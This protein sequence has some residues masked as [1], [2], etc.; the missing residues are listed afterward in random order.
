MLGR[1]RNVTLLLGIL[2]LAAL[3]PVARAQQPEPV[4]A[5]PRFDIERFVIEGNTLL[6]QEGIDR[7]VAPFSG[8]EK[9]FA[10]IQRALE[11]LEEAYRSAGWGLVQVVLPEQDITKGT[12]RFR[13]V[14]ARLS[15]VVVEGNQNFSAANI[16]RS[17]PALRE[18][19]TPNSRETAKNLQVAAENPGKQTTALL[20][21]GENEGEVI[22]VVQVVEEK[23]WK[24][25]ATLDN[26]GSAQTGDYRL[27]LGFLH[28][29]L[30]DRDHM[31]TAQ[32]IT[33][34][35]K[36]DEVKIFGAGYRIPLYS[37]GASIDVVAGYSD[38]NSGTVQNLFTVSGSGTIGA[39]RYNQHLPRLAD[40]EH[41]IVYGL[42]YRAYQNRVLTQGQS[43]VPDI[44][45]HPISAYYAGTY[46]A[47]GN[48][49]S[50]YLYAAQNVHP[51]GND[52][53]DDVFKAT[54]ADAKAS[55]RLYRYQAV[56]SRV[57]LKEWQFRATLNGQHSD[58]A[59]IPG[60]QF[61]VGG[62]ETVRGFQ[63]REVA[64]DKGFR[65]SLEV[66]SP[67]FGEK[68]GGKDFHTRALVFFDTASVY[69]NKA[70][71][72]EATE[73]SISSAGFGLRFALGKTASA[74][75]DYARVLD[76][77][78]AQ[79]KGDQRLHFSLSVVY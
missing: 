27:G 12:V 14:E 37:Q 41:K 2:A 46:R 58:E 18:G 70:Q 44:T 59:L 24:I 71:P 28:A 9:D 35:G 79:G 73:Q 4:L 1:S 56:Y 76:G 64:N 55:Y 74:R 63:E 47:S 45:V 57:F 62:A 16:R 30:F 34:P 69:R 65:T 29:N 50:F 43:I 22:A 51:H 42:D 66:I 48:D 33:S 49:F 11:A 53:T 7:A 20:R 61:G 36:W 52:A 19:T 40:Y 68:I 5:A 3:P 38:V 32:Y 39:L 6:P 75:F 54:R 72:G 60:E 13:I 77:G 17:V 21:S 25:S 8:K 15:K 23:P 67:D 78:G 31:L 10:D 26:T